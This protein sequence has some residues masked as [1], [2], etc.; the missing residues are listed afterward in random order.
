MIANYADLNYFGQV[1]SPLIDRNAQE[2]YGIAGVRIEP[3][4]KFRIDFG[5]RVK[6]RNFEDRRVTEFT[7]SFVD[8]RLHWQP[9]DWVTVTGA[10]DRFLREPAALRA[11]AD[12]VRSYGIAIDWRLAPQSGSRPRPISITSCRSAIN[13]TTISSAPSSKRSTNRCLTSN[14]SHRRLEA[15]PSNRSTTEFMIAIVSVEVCG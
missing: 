3:D 14:S 5:A 6:H 2:L 11:V 4:S 9:A 15:T 7:S 13:S 10:V 12:D 1:P 8:V